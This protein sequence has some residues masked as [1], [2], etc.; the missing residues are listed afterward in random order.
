MLQAAVCR[1]ARLLSTQ[2]SRTIQQPSRLILGLLFRCIFASLRCPR[3]VP[4]IL[5]ILP[6]NLIEK[7][8]RQSIFLAAGYQ[9]FQRDWPQQA[10]L[11]L[12]QYLRIARPSIEQRL[13]AANCLYQGL[14][15]PHDAIAL[16]ALG[17]E[18]DAKEAARLGLED[19]R[20]R[21]LD[22]VWARHIGHLG[23]L[24]Y[25][26]KLGVLEGRNREDVILYLPP[27]SVVANRFLLDQIA[28]HLRLIESPAELPFP[29]SAVR[30]L[31]FDLMGPRLSD[32][33][34][35]HYW[36]V[37]A[38]T[39]ARWHREGRAPLFA[40]PPAMQACGWAA[41]REAGIPEGAWFVALHVRERESDGRRSG[42][43]GVRNADI[44]TYLPAIAEITGRG[45]WVIRMGGSGMTRLPAL[46]KVVDYSVSAIRADWMDIFVLGCCRFMVGTNSG[47]AFVP[48]LY[49]MPAVITNWWPAGERPWRSS[50]I[51]VPKL[52]RRI[53]DGSY[54]TL[55]RT[56]CEPFGWSYSKNYLA[57]RCGVRLEDNDAEMIR[58]A[59]REMLDRID[60]NSPPDAEADELRARADRIY[61]ASGV[62]GMGQ[63]AREFVRR[64]ASLIT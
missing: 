7:L 15:R 31:H 35:A 5:P 57:E 55:G 1:G 56:L 14:G 46:T 43:N 26:L 41:L 21:V 20:Y 17:N 42:I 44:A 40:I 62:V 12:Q 61:N 38:E 48:A 32:G 63:L 51:F 45:G 37:A 50:D 22:S 25:V 36:K 8:G 9:L 58:A 47:P 2:V 23:I 29:E 34:T 52:L 19:G 59:V 54:L 28:Q 53:S 27:S 18:S 11:C 16:L 33:T 6:A 39:Y 4:I 30:A 10:W 24:D 3:L 64:H 60:G 13:L 49:G